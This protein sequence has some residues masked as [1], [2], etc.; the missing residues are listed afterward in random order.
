VKKSLQGIV[1]PSHEELIRG[2]GMLLHEIPVETLEWV[3]E[4]WIERLEW[5]S[6]SNGEYYP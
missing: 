2:F 1:F 3:F 6:Q 5:L 4:H